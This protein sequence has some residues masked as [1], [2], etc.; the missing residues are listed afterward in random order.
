VILAS[1]SG[2]HAVT[3]EAVHVEDTMDQKT[4]FLKYWDKEARHGK[5][6]PDSRGFELP[7]GPEVAWPR[8]RGHRA[9]AIAPARR[10]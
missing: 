8:D 2:S 7:A 10:A 9:E 1:R 4:L 3:V 6:L 5:V